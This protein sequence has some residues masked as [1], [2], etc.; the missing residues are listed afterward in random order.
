MAIRILTEDDGSSSTPRFRHYWPNRSYTI[1]G[2]QLI[3]DIFPP[4]EEPDFSHYE[5]LDCSSINF[6][7]WEPDEFAFVLYRYF[8]CNREEGENILFS[9]AAIRLAAAERAQSLGGND[10]EDIAA[11][12]GYESPEDL[13]EAADTY[14]SELLSRRAGPGVMRGNNRMWDY[15]LEEEDPD[16]LLDAVGIE[17]FSAECD[18]ASQDCTWS[19]QNNRW[20]GEVFMEDLA[21]HTIPPHD[22]T[23]VMILRGQ[24]KTPFGRQH[25]LL[26]MDFRLD[27]DTS[28]TVVPLQVAVDGEFRSDLVSLFE[29]QLV[30]EEISLFL[31]ASWDLSLSQLEGYL[32]AALLHE[33][34]ASIRRTFSNS[35]IQLPEFTLGETSSIETPLALSLPLTSSTDLFVQHSGINRPDP[36]ELHTNWNYTHTT[37]SE[38]DH[39]RLNSPF[40]FFVYDYP[41]ETIL[42]MG[43]L[44]D[45]GPGLESHESR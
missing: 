19:P 2:T 36:V 35:H 1:I 15:W 8:A 4:E 10:A 38:P 34:V 41:T 42:L 22:Y 12:L 20:T 37:G 32:S 44:V 14:R 3:L 9:P 11:R 7:E 27:T 24:Q 31:L 45:P 5:P 40:L 25:P 39:F 23:A 18:A 13:L 28:I 33:W 16:R 30:G 17:F 29:V 6:D 43:R 26:T 21:P